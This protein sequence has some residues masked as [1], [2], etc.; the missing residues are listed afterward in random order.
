MTQVTEASVGGAA[1]H[2][3]G[4]Q[5]VLVQSKVSGPLSRLVGGAEDWLSM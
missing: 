3:D 2:L 1:Y 4:M 5:L